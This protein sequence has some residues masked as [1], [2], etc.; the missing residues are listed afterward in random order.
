[1][2]KKNNLLEV[3]GGRVIKQVIIPDTEV[4]VGHCKQLEVIMEHMNRNA[5][6]IILFYLLLVLFLNL[7]QTTSH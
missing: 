7:Y 2:P 1:M 3:F 5:M 6:L 4:V